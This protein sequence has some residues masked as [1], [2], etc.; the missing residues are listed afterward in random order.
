MYVLAANVENLNTFSNVAHD[1]RG[2]AGNNTINGRNGN[3][4]LRL[5]DGGVDMVFAGAGNDNIFFGATLTAADRVVGGTGTD[6]LVIQGDYSGGL[7]LTNNHTQIENISILGGNN[8]NFG[9]PGTNR[10]DYVLTT[11]DF[12][13]AT[14]LQARINGAA[15]LQGEDFTFDGS[16]ETGAKFVVYGG[17]GVDTLTGGLGNDIFFFAEERFATGD[18]VNGGA[19]YDG[20]FL[21]GNYAINFNA[22]GYT[23][24]FTNIENLTL[25]SATDERYA[26]GGG[27]EFDYNLTL[28]D[29]IVKPGETLTVSG[30]LLMAN[31]TMVLNASQETD[32]FLRLFGGA[33]NDVLIG[34][35]NADLIHG[36]L[37]G[38]EIQGGG[39]ADV[40]RYQSTAESSGAAEATDR[41]LDFTPGTDKLDLARVDANTNVAGDQAFLFI[42]ASAFTGVAG[43]LRAF[44]SGSFWMVEGDTNGDGLA[45]LV[46][47]LDRLGP[48]P[49]A[50]SDFVL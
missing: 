27:S 43:E 29:A 23:G 16:A 41:I 34:G 7:T 45:D 48:T 9:E 15:L 5:Y 26:R 39:G 50:A 11:S 32:G 44:E 24:L 6:T 14:G 20:M 49:L 38:D 35:A 33:A 19:G 8:T 2:N 46:I 4:I 3:D 12:N 40:F 13:F 37:G 22:P 1:F 31:E 42:G 21:R 36:A 10:Y 47:A 25:T 30:A 18:T 17:K 28:S